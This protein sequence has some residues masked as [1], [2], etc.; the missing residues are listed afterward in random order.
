MLAVVGTVPDKAFPLIEG[1]VALEGDEIVIQDRRVQVNRGTP[2][3][4]AAALMTGKELEQESPHAYLVGD[5]GKGDGSRQLYDYLSRH[6]SRLFFRTMV[7]HY[8]QPDTDW[9]SRVFFA[10]EAMAQR[11]VLI[12]DA[13]FMY[14]AKM[15]GQALEYDLFTPDAG[16][17]AFLADE[18]A[19]HPFYTRGFILHEDKKI[20]QLIARAYEHQ[21]AARCLLVKGQPDYVANQQGVVATIDSP[22]N[23]AMEAIGGT[24]DTITGIVAALIEGGWGVAEAAIAAAQINRMAGHYAAPTPASSV[25]ELIRYIPRA[26]REILSR[27][28][29]VKVVKDQGSGIDPEMTVLEVVSRYRQTEAVFRKYDE[30][31][32]ECICCEALFDSLRSV[33]ERY[34]LSLDGLLRN[35]Q[36]AIRGV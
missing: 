16:E 13:G 31:A 17:L 36:A 4:L 33:C 3:L 34:G 8:L 35:L 32:G 24:G 19:P 7:F 2:A 23:E 5:I 11:P 10:L 21:N 22:V 25:M 1:E 9:H 26:A 6:V 15:S 14:A 20:T 28:S 29:G 18:E 30:Q 12:A 27:G